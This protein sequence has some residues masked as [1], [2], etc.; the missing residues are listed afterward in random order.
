MPVL[1]H[2]S[3]PR[4]PLARC[5]RIGRARLR[6][7]RLRAGERGL[8]GL[9]HADRSGHEHRVEQH[10]VEQRGGRACV[11]RAA[12]PRFRARRHEGRWDHGV[13]DVAADDP[14]VPEGRDGFGGCTPTVRPGAAITTLAAL[15][16]KGRAPK[17]GYDRGQFGQA[18]ADVDRN[19]CDTRNDILRR[20]LVRFTLKAGTNGCLVLRGTLKDPYTGRTIAFVR[21]PGTSTAVQI[22]HVVAL[23]DAWQKGA[24]QWSTAKRTAFANDPLNLL[25]VDGPTNAAKGDGDAA[26]WLPPTKAVRCSYVARQVAVKHRYGLWVTAAERDAVI[27]VLSG[28]P[29]QALP[30]AKTIP[31]GGGAVATAVTSTPARTSSS[32][33]PSATAKT[34]RTD[35][36][37]RT[38]REANAAGYGPYRRG[39]DPE[40]DWYLDRDHDGLVCER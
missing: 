13:T 4:H 17:T 28:C 27:R 6:G 22:D 14:R 15:P 23:S 34:S 37:F 9:L 40:Y 19:G 12:D 25:A 38:C 29:G 16:V 3:S 20:D 18:W 30:T 7:L 26:T 11:S 36:Q 21:G 35:P 10:R 5:H 8:A 33:R 2:D 31:L 39:V 24:Q 32:P 1:P